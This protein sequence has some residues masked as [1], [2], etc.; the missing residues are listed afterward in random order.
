M[1]VAVV[2]TGFIGGILG[3][4]IAAAGHDVVFASRNPDG[5]PRGDLGA[6]RVAAI[7]E[8]L[9]DADVVLLAIPGSAVSDFSRQHALEL[10]GKLVVDATNRMD[11]TVANSRAA[12]PA[13]VRYG[14]AFNTL[15]GENLEQPNF[16][17]G[18]ADMFFSGPEGD[19][20]T[21]EALIAATGLRPVYLG[22]DQEALVDA[23]FRVWIALA[24][25]QHRGRRLA[26][27]LL[28]G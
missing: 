22:P 15:G 16:V 11:Q 3:R 7:S 23:L 18:P 6:A 24:I 27:R 1:R 19:R 2:G 28:E 26:L 4:R 10:A 13:D 21:L 9:G 25:G 20:D 14:R 8:A 12:L 17:D 5:E